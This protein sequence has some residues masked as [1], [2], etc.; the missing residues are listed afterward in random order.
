MTAGERLQA[1]IQEELDANGCELDGREQALLERAINCADDIEKLE[2][3]LATQGY[4]VTVK[5]NVQ[6][7]PALGEVRRLRQLL[8]SL[9]N[10]IQLTPPAPGPRTAAA[11]YSR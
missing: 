7:H 11:R 8:K 2:E 10:G 5:G 1:Q 3:I 4:T 6:M 9:L